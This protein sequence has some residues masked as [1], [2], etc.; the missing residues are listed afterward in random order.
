M[1]NGL[2]RLACV[3]ATVILAPEFLSYWIRSRLWGRDR[4]LEGSSQT[5][6]LIPGIVGQVFRRAFLTR[7][8]D[9]CHPDTTVEFGT[10]FSKAGT[11][12]DED[13]YIGPRCHIGW[14]HLERDVL[15]AASVH[16]PS[17]PMTHGT[18]DPVRRI[19]DQPGLLQ[20]IRI[21]A[22]TWVGSGAVIMAD[23]GSDSIIGAGAVV[24]KPIP[25]RVLAAGVPA[26]VV[27]NRESSS[28]PEELAS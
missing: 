20:Q 22:G 15:I 12:I 27:R 24:T 7:V 17:G 6:S 26:R 1:K 19:Q 23:V 10:I 8:L 25:D 2:K 4:A 28:P 9:Y 16:I 13:V 11:R 18:A 5:L 21:G 14:A 3:V